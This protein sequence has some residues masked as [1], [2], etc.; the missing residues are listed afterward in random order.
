MKKLIVFCFVVF[1]LVG[2]TVTGHT[3]EKPDTPV[4]VYSLVDGAHEESIAYVDES[5]NLIQVSVEQ[6]SSPTRVNAGTY[7]ISKSSPGNWSVSYDIR[8]NS[9][10]QI[11]STANL[12]FTTPRGSITSRSL[13]HTASRAVC[14]F[15]Y[16][17]GLVN[18]NQSLTAT[19]S[20]GKIVIT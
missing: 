13:T 19:I 12:S 7:R 3:Q 20:N 4:I 8:V 9:N 15:T 5:G 6:L 11:T 10:R 16:R 17:Y 18:S 2:S 1:G 14:N